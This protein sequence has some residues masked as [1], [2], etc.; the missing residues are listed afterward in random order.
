MLLINGEPR[1][2]LLVA[3]IDF[4][5]DRK[6][7]SV[8]MRDLETNQLFLFCKG[9]DSII[10]KRVTPDTSP[11]LFDKTKEDLKTF[12]KEGLR[13]LAVAYKELDEAIFNNWQKR[14]AEEQQEDFNELLEDDPKIKLKQV[15]LFD[16]EEKNNYCNSWKK[17]WRVI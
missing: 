9:A 16:K 8:V 12:S 6:R 15:V 7:M 3:K 11:E 10:L 17:N 5:S 4:N 13:T 2:F 1:E 14:Y